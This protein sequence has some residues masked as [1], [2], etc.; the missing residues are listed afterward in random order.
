MYYY[1]TYY[2]LLLAVVVISFIV[3]GMVNSRFE[4]Y[5]KVATRTGMTGKEVA[6][7]ILRDA[8]I[9][10]VSVKFAQGSGLSDHYDPMKRV[11]RLSERVINSNSVAAVSVAAHEASHALQHAENYKP[12]VLRTACV[13][14]VNFGSR[15]SMLIIILGLFL[16]FTPL[17]YVGVALYSLV[18]FFALITLPVEFNASRRALSILSDTG[19]V[20]ADELHGAKSVLSAAAMTY[21]VSA[22]SAVIQLLRLVALANRAKDRD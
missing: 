16:S 15:F 3:Q 11:L 8:G 1:D 9:S 22:L 19:V 21:V 17:L 13:N 4:K 2:F 14:S 12:L 20:S 5:S 10:D 6:E 7:K 18:V